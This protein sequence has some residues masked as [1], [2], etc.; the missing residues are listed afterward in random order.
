MISA[1]FRPSSTVPTCTCFYDSICLS[2]SLSASHSLFLTYFNP[3]LPLQAQTTS[4]LRRIYWISLVLLFPQNYSMSRK[5]ILLGTYTY[6]HRHFISPCHHTTDP[7][8]TLRVTVISHNQLFTITHTFTHT[9]WLCLWGSV[10][11]LLP[12]FGLTLILSSANTHTHSL[13]LTLPPSISLPFSLFLSLSLRLAV[14]AVL[15]LKGSGNLDYIQVIN[16]LLILCA[17]ITLCLYFHLYL[18]YVHYTIVIIM[19]YT[20]HQL[21]CVPCYVH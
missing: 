6:E 17:L 12:H 19:I 2:F 20:Q 13:S 15:R 8:D 4:N 14:D 7:K 11:V 9:P 1:P 3:F 18:V 5:I 16:T 10:S 21:F